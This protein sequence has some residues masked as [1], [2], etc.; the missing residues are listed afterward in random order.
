MAKDKKPS[1]TFKMLRTS[2]E[3]V[4]S[5][6]EWFWIKVPID[7]DRFNVDLREDFAAFLTELRELTKKL[8][9]SPAPGIKNSVD[10]NIFVVD[11][12]LQA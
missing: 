10:V 12:M 4:R 2:V 3:E 11:E 9:N 1:D 6:A 8:V 7:Y 5:H